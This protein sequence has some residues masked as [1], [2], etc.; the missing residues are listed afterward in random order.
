M[1]DDTII[2]LDPVNRNIINNAISSGVRTFAGGNCTVSLMLMAL[3]GL[4]KNDLVEWISSMTYQAASG[5]GAKNMTELI[6]QTKA[7][8]DAAADTL[9][10]PASTA[11]ELDKII[12]EEQRKDS[13][14]ADNFKVPLA[15]SLIPWIDSR[16]DNGQSREEW[17]GMAETNKILQ[18]ENPV[19]VDGLCVRIGAMRCHSQGFTI[20]LKRDI[21]VR[22]IES[23]LVAGTHKW[24]KVISNEIEDS[25]TKLTP[26]A[27]S[28]KLEVPVGRIRKMTMGPEYLAAFSV[29]DQLLWGAAEPVWRMLKIIQEQF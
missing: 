11:L 15:C 21:P 16:L 5:A 29:G 20:K 12:T 2:V 28:G 8:G 23:I 10:N 22:E 4:F 25:I 27:V 26:A 24:V 17:K 7:L 18:N 6:K 14:P 9:S 19:P 13:F 1:K 3:T